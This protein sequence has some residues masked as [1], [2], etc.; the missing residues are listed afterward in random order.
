MRV[1]VAS[2]VLLGCCLLVCGQ[3]L[4]NAQT[5]VAIKRDAVNLISPDNFREPLSLSASRSVD[6]RARVEGLIQNVRIKPG[7]K[8]SS[9]EELVRIDSAQAAKQLDRARAGLK[10]ATLQRDLVKTQ[11]GEGTQSQVALDLAE[12]QLDVAEADLELAQLNYDQASVRAPFAGMVTSLEAA[13][14][15]FAAEGDKLLTL[16]DANELTVQIPVNRSEVKAGDSLTV[17]LAEGT[18]TGK[19]QAI[20]PLDTK[21]QG[22]RQLV[23]TAALAVVTIENQNGNYQV[24]QTVY[25][26]IVPRQPVL[27]IANS[28]L[29]NSESGTRLVQVIRGQMIRDIEVTLLGPVGE[30]RSYVSGPF[31]AQDE[32]ITETSEPLPDGTVVRANNVPATEAN[33]NTRRQ[34]N[35][36]TNQN[37]GRPGF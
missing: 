3:E 21:W 10:A 34:P 33:P 22:L 32:I 26:P 9:Q 8:V 7:A 2:K 17:Q 13:Q 25:S 4:A 19:V 24:G 28:S 29:K 1:A 37:D 14:G 27:E 36:N 30:G 6:I 11:V 5:Q 31:Q 23:E 15:A 16:Q 20:L 12:A 18:A 35:A